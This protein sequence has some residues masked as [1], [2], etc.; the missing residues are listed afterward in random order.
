MIKDYKNSS[1]YNNAVE[2][3][4]EEEIEENYKQLSIDTIYEWFYKKSRKSNVN[5]TLYKNDDIDSTIKNSIG[6]MLELPNN[7]KYGLIFV[8]DVFTQEEYDNLILSLEDNN[9]IPVFLIGHNIIKYTP[10]YHIVLPECFQYMINDYHTPVI[11]NPVSHTLHYCVNNNYDLMF[12]TKQEDNTIITVSIDDCN[13]NPK[14]GFVFDGFNDYYKNFKNNVDIFLEEQLEIKNKKKE[15]VDKVESEEV[16]KHRT[17]YLIDKD[18]KR[19]D[20]YG[21]EKFNNIISKNIFN[22]DNTINYDVLLRDL[23]EYDDYDNCYETI[24]SIDNL[25]DSDIKNV[26]FW[27]VYLYYRIVNNNIG[28][29]Y[30]YVTVFQLVKYAARELVFTVSP[31]AYKIYDFLEELVSLHCLEK[32]QELE[33]TVVNDDINNDILEKYLL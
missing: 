6:L 29:N 16:E 2:L 28:K 22:D 15:I 33:Y 14:T 4:N 31:A 12:D 10:S 13:F 17:Y 18:L 9:I 23:E 7:K 8:Y 27:K 20:Y 32:K 5:I 21:I 24:N 25:N 1:Y 3:Y 26:N 30:D 19:K 11:I